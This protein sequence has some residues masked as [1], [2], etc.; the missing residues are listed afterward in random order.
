[1]K[2]NWSGLIED[3]N[4]T[5]RLDL[6]PFSNW[7]S[8]KKIAPKCDMVVKKLI[9]SDLIYFYLTRN[10]SAFSIM[11]SNFLSFY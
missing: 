9:S 10:I 6:H 7:A 3:I 4:N 8:A 5:C 2:Y 1:M 11:N